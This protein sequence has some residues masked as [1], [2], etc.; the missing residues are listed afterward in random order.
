MKS[1]IS[2]LNLLSST[3]TFSSH[4]IQNK[5]LSQLNVNINQAL[6][7]HEDMS[8]VLLT[9]SYPQ[10]LPNQRIQATDGGKQGGQAS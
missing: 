7:H 6:Q 4:C 9:G 5:L 8:R 2:P 10:I 3:H 1:W